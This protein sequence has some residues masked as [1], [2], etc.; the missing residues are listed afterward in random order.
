MS[1]KGSATRPLSQIEPTESVRKILVDWSLPN[2][3]T[4]ADLIT[5]REKL[6]SHLV[7]RPY[8][9]IQKRKKR[10]FDGAGLVLKFLKMDTSI[11]EKHALI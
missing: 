8:D 10:K 7:F 11:K 1:E 4:P 2:I 3:N 9:N 5:L 6:F